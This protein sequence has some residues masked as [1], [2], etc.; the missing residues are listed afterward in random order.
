MKKYE[1]RIKDR[2]EK[3]K[4]GIL[5][6]FYYGSFYFCNAYIYFC[7]VDKDELYLFSRYILFVLSAG[8]SS[9]KPLPPPPTLVRPPMT[10]AFETLAEV[11]IG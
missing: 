10:P 3:E 9:S 1:K 2:A 5:H 6:I 4:K 7:Y 11:T 8:I